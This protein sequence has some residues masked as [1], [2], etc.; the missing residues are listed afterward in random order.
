M[1]RRVRELLKESNL[2]MFLMWRRR[3]SR[4]HELVVEVQR[5]LCVVDHFGPSGVGRGA[6]GVFVVPVPPLV[7]WGLGVAWGRVFP[8]LLASECGHVEVV[9]DAPHGFVAAAVDEVS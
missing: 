5:H 7:R 6:G 2:S 9:P 1:L 4:R 3:P 8:D